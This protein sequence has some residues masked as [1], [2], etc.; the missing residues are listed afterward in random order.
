MPSPA[1]RERRDQFGYG[2]ARPGEERGLEAGVRPRSRTTQV[3]HQVDD[4]VQF[5]GLDASKNS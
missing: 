2:A 1:L 3:S 4:P 5:V